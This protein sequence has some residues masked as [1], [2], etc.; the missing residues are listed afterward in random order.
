MDDQARPGA[1]AGRDVEDLLTAVVANVGEALDLWSV[2]LWAFSVDA[3]TL[4]CRA[5]WCRDPETTKSR[6]CVGAVIG[7]DQS[8]DLR[9]L[10]LTGQIV[11]HHVDDELA[12]ADAAALAQAGFTH[13]VDVP[14]LAGAEVLGV[15]SLAETRPGRRLSDED[16]SRLTTLSRLAAAVL[17][18]S[19]LYET[20]VA[21]TERLTGML[22]S[23]RGISAARTTAAIVAA[24]R[25]EAA[26][27]VSGVACDAQVV[28]RQDDGTFAP[29][30]EAG[31]ARAAPG[32]RAD[33]LAR[34]AADL[35]R[36]EQARTAD[37]RARLLLPLLAGAR[38]SGYLELTAGLRRPFRQA[39]IELAS[40]LAGQTA[41][42][43]ERAKAF[44]A[45][46]SR[47]ATDTLTGL[48]SRWY[49]HERLYAEV[50]RARRYRQPLSLVVV[51]LD[52]EEEL[53]RRRGAAHRDASLA[54]LARLLVTSLRDK[55]D[56]ACRLGGG[57]FALL[58]PNTPPG[59]DAAGLVAE[60]VRERVAA[61]R[62][63]DDELGA[64]GRFTMSLGVAGFP[65]SAE[66]ADDLV[67]VAEGR[68]ATARAAGG[69]RVEPPPPE[70]EEEDRDAGAPDD[71]PG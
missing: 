35:G 43:L 10:V 33:A 38:S 17:R 58:L 30:G 6:G 23:G 28:L 12:P 18:A 15:L 64:L 20:E 37:G 3:D 63:S 59:P 54:A 25:E 1:V 5:Y 56:V 70:P 68:L 62:L 39:E 51:E 60:R 22:A 4:A 27:L 66:D 24:V 52:G 65:E 69:D 32:W 34:Q 40:L 47:S 11:E 50:A 71:E 9:R 7:L 67:R 29:A 46:Q 44:R 45:V 13:R 36:P 8:H 26:R 19:G 57:R 53:A 49:F 41:A 48:Y 14:L 21:R 55:V 61:T 42:A 2:D 31:A 16:R